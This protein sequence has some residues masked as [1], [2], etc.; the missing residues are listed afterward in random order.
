[1]KFQNELTKINLEYKQYQSSV[2]PELENLQ[3]E[4]CLYKHE[5]DEETDNKLKRIMT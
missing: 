2:T 4:L 3:R 5:L 1:M